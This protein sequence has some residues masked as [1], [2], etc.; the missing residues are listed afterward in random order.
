MNSTLKTVLIVF[1]VLFLCLGCLGIGA[2]GFVIT[3]NIKENRETSQNLGTK[4]PSEEAQS[5]FDFLSSVL[6]SDIAENHFTTTGIPS[7][8]PAN[9]DW[10]PIFGQPDGTYKLDP[11]HD[12]F[13]Q[14]H[15]YWVEGV[16]SGTNPVHSVFELS[17]VVTVDQANIWDCGVDNLSDEVKH[18]LAFEFTDKKYVNQ[19]IQGLSKPYHVVTPFGI[20]D[21]ADGEKPAWSPTVVDSLAPV[22]PFATPSLSDP[23]GVPVGDGFVGAPGKAGCDFVLVSP[24]GKTAVRYQNAIDVFPYPTGSSFYLF[25]P[26][27]DNAAV[28]AGI[29]GNPVVTNS[30]K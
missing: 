16:I 15:S 23:A 29:A 27:L 6:G 17:A 8:Y 21:Y 14:D 19:S 10:K 7:C 24:D 30:W 26:G 5:P 2:A 25:A 3:G 4:T 18:T 13:N 12:K 9:F 28:S 20:Y 22:C 1:T 11:A